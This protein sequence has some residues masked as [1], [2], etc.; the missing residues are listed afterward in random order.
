[1]NGKEYYQKNK[2]TILKR[3][4]E[5]YKKNIEIVKQ[6]AMEYYHKNKEKLSQKS[7]ENYYKKQKEKNQKAKEYYHKNKEVR[8][9]YNNMY[10]HMHKQNYVKKYS[11]ENYGFFYY[12]N[13]TKIK[14]SKAKEEFFSTLELIEKNTLEYLNNHEINNNNFILIF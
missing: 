14:N 3:N 6:K 9:E 4:K 13:V 2:E 10:W 5:Y 11:Y 7:K 12:Q 1:M 8:K